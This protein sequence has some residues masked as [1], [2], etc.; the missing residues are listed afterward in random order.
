[1]KSKEINSHSD[2]MKNKSQMLT[3]SII[4][5]V[6]SGLSVDLTCVP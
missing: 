2:Y 1:M 5:S 3:F 4:T 6:R